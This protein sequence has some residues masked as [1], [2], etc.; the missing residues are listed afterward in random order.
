MSG[1]VLGSEKTMSKTGILHFQGVYVDT[2]VLCIGA[3]KK[4]HDVKA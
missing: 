3:V 1:T 4:K 2:E